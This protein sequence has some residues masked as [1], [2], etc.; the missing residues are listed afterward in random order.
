MP[1]TQTRK[2][3]QGRSSRSKGDLFEVLV[4]LGLGKHYNLSPKELEEER[5]SLEKQIITQF[6]DGELRVAEQHRRAKIA[7]SCIVRELEVRGNGNPIMINWIGRGWQSQKTLADVRVFFANKSSIGISLKST[8]Q[9]KGTQKNLGYRSV[10]ALLGLDIDKELA[11]MWVN[12]RSSMKKIPALKKL[13]DTSMAQIKRLKYKFPIIQTIGKKYGEVVQRIAVARSVILFNKLSDAK[14]VLFLEEIF[15]NQKNS[16]LL[17]NVLVAG[18]SI[19]IGW[20]DLEPSV[21]K[22]GLVAKS[23]EDKSYGIF[24]DNQMVVRIQASFTN[25]IGLSPFCERAFLA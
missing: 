4:C 15:G 10:R 6:P 19:L 14:K 5:V 13:S 22:S 2:Q 12:I 24:I 7:L 23:L 25:G 20:S 1:K 21:S 16:E 18:D 11:E 17:L 3:S 8:R 9:G